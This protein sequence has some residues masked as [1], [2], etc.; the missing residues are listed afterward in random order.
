[1]DE[2]GA[3]VDS[4]RPA[5]LLR[6][7][8][9]TGDSGKAR[10]CDRRTWRSWWVQPGEPGVLGSRDVRSTEPRT[11]EGYAAVLRELSAIQAGD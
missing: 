9:A 5:G 10:G 1:M 6:P 11:T 7:C 4:R 3:L 8:R 2:V